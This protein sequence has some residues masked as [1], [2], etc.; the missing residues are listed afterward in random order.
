MKHLMRRLAPDNKTLKEHRHF[1]VFGQ[2]LLDPNLWHLNRRSAA[3][4][5][6]HSARARARSN[7]A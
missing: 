3:G 2:W 1:K 6:H 7:A 5:V 4:S